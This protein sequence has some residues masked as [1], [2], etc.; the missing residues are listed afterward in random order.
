MMMVRSFITYDDAELKAKDMW[1]SGNEDFQINLTNFIKVLTAIKCVSVKSVF[2]SH[3]QIS[4][5]ESGF[6]W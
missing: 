4:Q 1:V 6:S 5:K 3:L 2:R